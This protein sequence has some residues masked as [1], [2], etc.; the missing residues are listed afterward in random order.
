MDAFSFQPG[1]SALSEYEKG[2]LNSFIATALSRRKPGRADAGI[3][4]F[5]TKKMPAHASLCLSISTKKEWLNLSG[6]MTKL[7]SND[8]KS[9]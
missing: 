4:V 2:S 5:S 8:R 6:Q 1:R 7:P 3:L 9:H